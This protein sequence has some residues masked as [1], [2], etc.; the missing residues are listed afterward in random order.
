MREPKF[1]V[2]DV[3]RIANDEV[4][5]R[6]FSRIAGKHLKVIAVH[7]TEKTL[8]YELESADGSWDLVI[9]DWL[10]G[11]PLEEVQRYYADKPRRGF[12]VDGLTVYELESGQ[13]E[14]YE[15]F[16][17]AAKDAESCEQIQ[18]ETKEAYNRIR[19]CKLYRKKEDAFSCI[20]GFVFATVCE[21]A[22]WIILWLQGYLSWSLSLAG[23]VFAAL[24]ALYAAHHMV[25]LIKGINS[26]I[27]RIDDENDSIT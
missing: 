13:D 25:W 16:Q 14:A 6:L 19:R 10:E 20:I 22:T 7:R 21:I 24:M 27:E 5:Q 15:I 1:D 23:A 2:G 26:E 9:E 17:Q 11:V 8:G 18:K 12:I 4:P 3:V